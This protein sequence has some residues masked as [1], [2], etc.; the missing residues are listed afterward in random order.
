MVDDV[1]STGRN[2]GPN[3]ETSDLV[4]LGFLVASKCADR[5]IQFKVEY[6]VVSNL[7]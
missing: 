2:Q 1:K 3:D 7:C 6:P 4:V 5:E